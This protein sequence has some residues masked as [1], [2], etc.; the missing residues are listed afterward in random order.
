MDR[1]TQDFIWSLKHRH[2][3]V[4]L[5]EA[6]INFMAGRT[7][8]AKEAYTPKRL[9]GIVRRFFCDYMRTCDFPGVEVEA[10]F[11]YMDKPWIADETEAILTTLELV[12]VKEDGKY[13]NG[14]DGE[15]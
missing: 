1:F 13:V 9:N 11:E 5:K 3:G 4:T 15:G 8:S 12:Q 7:W 2:E 6:A 10:L 14:F